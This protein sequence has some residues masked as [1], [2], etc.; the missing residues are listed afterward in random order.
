MKRIAVCMALC[1]TIGCG[2]SPSQ[3]ERPMTPVT[4]TPVPAPSA[5]PLVGSWT[6]MFDVSSCTGSVE[7]CRRT[8][9]EPFSLRLDDSL[10]GV[11]EMEPWR[12]QLLAL[13][14]AQTSST[15]G[16]TILNGV[17]TISG[18]PTID[19]EIRLEGSAP[20]G[21][22]GSVRYTLTG[23][24]YGEPKSSVVTRTGPI[25]FIRPVTT[26]RAG[27]LQGTWRGYM[28][29]TACSGECGDAGQ[30]RDVTLWLS[31][32][33]S[34]LSAI[35][36]GDELEGT[37][38]GRDFTLTQLPIPTKCNNP[39]RDATVCQDSYDFRGSVDSLDRMRGTIQRRRLGY[40]YYDGPFSWT[41]TLELEGVV[42]AG[43]SLAR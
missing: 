3:S 9:P 36:N 20:S 27:A 30:I 7:W 12:R 14:I 22:S 40:D 10:R 26:V 41:A 18:Q 13:D 28:K 24:P 42:R 33:G 4:P 37:V 19:L 11:A 31:Q 15:D 34:T 23:D 5:P 35:F 1:A 29:R 25:L 17:S 2:S 43:S 21:L 32:Q 39:V 16:S 6:G 38:S 8:E